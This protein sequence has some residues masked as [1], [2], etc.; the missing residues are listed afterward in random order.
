[1]NVDDE[2]ERA[3]QAR[4][5]L[6]AQ[7][8]HEEAAIAKQKN[9]EDKRK[10]AQQVRNDIQALVDEIDV[11]QI[12]NDQQELVESIQQIRANA[13]A[14]KE[15]IIERKRAE[16]LKLQQELESM[17]ED[18]NQS[19][20]VE[21]RARLKRI[22]ALRAEEIAA[23][24]ARRVAE[25]SDIKFDPT[26]TPATRLLSEMSMLELQERLA[27]AKIRERQELEGLKNQVDF[28]RR[29]RE[30]KKQDVID[31]VRAFRETS[32]LQEMA[33]RSAATS[34]TSYQSGFTHS[35]SVRRLNRLELEELKQVDL[36]QQKLEKRREQRLSLENALQ[37]S[38]KVSIFFIVSFH[39][40]HSY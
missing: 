20:E 40:N 14:S 25:S 28:E 5:R 11:I 27:M 36:L 18:F 2:L 33:D 38:I 30:T 29:Q 39:L 31:R 26:I 32:K 22:R 21:Q 4:L 12:A 1:M 35:S 13:V 37:S 23:A 24:L 9:I 8:S 7:L 15:K 10:Q 17:Q 34:R 16:A 3:K 19:M 6:F